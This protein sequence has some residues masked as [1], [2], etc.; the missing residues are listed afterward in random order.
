M[1]G[2]G[3]AVV[4]A[5]IDNELGGAAEAFQRLVHLLTAEDGN[6]PVDITTHEKSGG[7]D[8]VGAKEGRDFFPDGFVFPRVAEF[9]EVVFL[10]L[11]VAE[12]AGYQGY[13]RAGDRGFEA[14]G[15]GAMMKSVDMPP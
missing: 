13:A 14:R 2:R 11:I 6:V 8:V 12:A 7:G 1:G 3:E 15:L 10:I 9:G 4:L 5:G